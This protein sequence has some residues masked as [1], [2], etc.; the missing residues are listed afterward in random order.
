MCEFPVEWWGVSEVAGGPL[1]GAGSGG[2]FFV[3]GQ[4][5][6][7]G[8]ASAGRPV[9]WAGGEVWKEAWFIVFISSYIVSKEGTPQQGSP[10]SAWLL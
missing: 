5:G 1:L 3:G 10:H 4:A 6:Q 9:A 7:G 8:V 2:P